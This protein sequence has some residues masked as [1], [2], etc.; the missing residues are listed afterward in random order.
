MILA[1]RHNIDD[2][3][4]EVRDLNSECFAIASI[5]LSIPRALP[6]IQ[7]VCRSKKSIFARHTGTKIIY[8]IAKLMGYGVLPHLRE[9]V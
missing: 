3:K 8:Y 4:S 2:S 6:F 9:L 7:A 1:T 5:A